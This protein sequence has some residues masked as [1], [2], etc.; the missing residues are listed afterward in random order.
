MAQEPAPS[1]AHRFRKSIGLTPASLAAIVLGALGA[2][3]L[4]ACSSDDFTTDDGT[5]T[6]P[7]GTEGGG[8]PGDEGGNN[9]GDAA[10]LPFPG[11]DGGMINYTC[12]RDIHVATTGT[13]GAAGTATAP[14]KSIV[15]AVATAQPG[16]CV[17]VHAGTYAETARIEFKTDGTPTQ[18]IVVWSVDGR[19]KAVIDGANNR[20]GP[21]VII[22]QDNVVIDGFEFK[23]NPID[24]DEQ[25]VHFDGL[26]TGKGA[27]S[28]LRNCKITGGYDHLK[29]NQNAQGVL[30]EFNEF[31][32]KFGHLPLSLTSAPGLVLRGNFMHDWDTGD[33]GAVQLKGGS[34][35]VL[36]E[37]NMFQDVVTPAGAIAMGDGCDSTCDIDPDHYAAVRVK[38]MNNVFVRVGRGFDI[39]GC[40]DCAVLNNTFV[41]SGQGNVMFKLT[42]AATNGNSRDT[43]NARIQNNLIANPKG[44][45]SEMIQI[46]GNN[47]QGLQM[48][49]NFMW[50]GSGQAAYGDSHPAGQ[51]AHSVLN[52]DPKLVNAAAGDF[53]LSAGSPAIGAGLNI[54]KDVSRD[55]LGNARPATKPFDVGAYQTP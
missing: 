19:G 48:D 27:G 22:R 54:V 43:V 49:Y 17:K 40:K 45:G 30:V 18:P 34:H 24:T 29:I 21:G 3:A 52:K 47:G 8:G 6:N 36:I 15:K 20:P 13:D 46:N 7:N 11:P 1:V 14:H 32:G 41:D 35:D 16:D 53:K 44:D 37:G 23:N 39:Q 38:A 50:N 31:Y 5:G 25:V 10:N 33:N 12:A 2:F 26:T 28:V 55:I 4:G 42:T 51:D 9:G